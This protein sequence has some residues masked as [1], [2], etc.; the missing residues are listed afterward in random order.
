MENQWTHRFNQKSLMIAVHHW[1]LPSVSK[2]KS[3]SEPDTKL[4][5]NS[6]LEEIIFL[7]PR[8]S[9]H[10]KYQHLVQ[11]NLYYNKINGT[12]KYN[13]HKHKVPTKPYTR[14]IRPGKNVHIKS[15]S[16]T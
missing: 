10:M 3:H 4:S 6:D 9:L 13:Q 5:E 2:S 12:K 8:S 1:L 14:T 11:A 7:N 16:F 15:V